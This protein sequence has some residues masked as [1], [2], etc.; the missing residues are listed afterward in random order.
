MELGRIDTEM[1]E[2][3]KKVHDL[4]EKDELFSEKAIITLETKEQRRAVI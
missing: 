3:C 2:S 4:Y 1:L